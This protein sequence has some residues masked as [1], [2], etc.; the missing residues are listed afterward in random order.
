MTVCNAEKRPTNEAMIFPKK[1]RM[2]LVLVVSVLGIVPITR[3]ELP[4]GEG[5]VPQ[6]TRV[7]DLQIVGVSP[8]A[9]VR[10]HQQVQVRFQLGVTL[11]EG[12]G[13]LKPLSA[14]VCPTSDKGTCFV[15]P[16]VQLQ[17]YVGVIEAQAPTAGAGAKVRIQ[18]VTPPPCVGSPTCTVELMSHLDVKPVTNNNGTDTIAEFTMPVAARY[19]VGIT[20]FQVYRP[21]AMTLDT[22]KISLRSGLQGDP[23]SSGPCDVVTANFCRV[24]VAEGDHGSTG[25]LSLR[26][27]P[28]VLVND[29]RVGPYDLIPEVSENLVFQYDVENLGMQYE[30]KAL[31]QIL[32]AMSLAAAGILDGLM[33]SSGV[34]SGPFDKLDSFANKIQGLDQC[35][36]PVAVDGV[37]LLNK[38]FP[39]LQTLDILTRDTGVYSSAAKMYEGTDSVGCGGNSVYSVT[40][41]VFRTS[42]EPARRRTRLPLPKMSAH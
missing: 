29:I 11:R 10:E 32:D 18:L 22:V 33:N 30:Q 12:G 21:R 5:Q 38:H 9:G 35:D 1:W 6:E 3:A 31:Q 25:V 27:V 14:A 41:T 42:W 24:N 8:S 19:E 36:G 23:V 17:T 16:D 13:D 7:Y 28:P 15:I 2:S 4:P 26:N 39:G 40:W 34:G 20:S 37:V